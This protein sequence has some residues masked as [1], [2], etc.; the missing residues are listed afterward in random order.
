MNDS[1]AAVIEPTVRGLGF[2]LEAVELRGGGKHRTLLV[3]I[4][5]DAGVG[6]DEITDV[7]RALAP[8]LDQTDVMGESPYTLEVT[9]RGVDRPLTEPRHWRRNRGRLVAVELVDTERF[10]A[11]IGSSDDEGVDLDVRGTTTRFPY[12]DISAAVI[13]VELNRKDV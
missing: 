1:I 3:A 9:S 5:S 7:T 4:D 2:D 13:Q 6:I 8:V 12:S 10:E 11:R